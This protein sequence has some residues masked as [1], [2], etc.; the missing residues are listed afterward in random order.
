[1][2][3]AILIDLSG[4]LHIENQVI[5]G[6]IDAL[7][8]LLVTGL[9]VKFVTNTTKESKNFLHNRLTKIGFHLKKEDIFSSL[10]AARNLLECRKWK[11]LLLLSPEALEDFE[12]LGCEKEENPN[13]VLVG[14]APNEFHYERLNEAFRC[15]LNGSQLIAIHAGKYYKTESGL[16]LG[17]GC[18][19][20]GLEYSAQCKA[21]IVGKPTKEFFLAALDDIPPHEAV[22][23]GDDVT[24]DIQGAQRTGIRGYLVQTGKYKEGDEHKISPEPNAVFPSIVEAIDSILDEVKSNVFCDTG[25]GGTDWR[26][27][28]GHCSGCGGGR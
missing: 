19:V 22:M 2:I 7:N 28:K 27:S 13:A 21:E 18:F 9:K 4:T 24:D 15:L 23:I 11:S 16:S 12:G 10:A 1:M 8:K 14:L 6:A 25:F 20:K 5:P 26:V 17:P 3:R